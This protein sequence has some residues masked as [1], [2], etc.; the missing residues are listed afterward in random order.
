MA[1]LLLLCAP[2]AVRCRRFA[3]QQAAVGVSAQFGCVLVLLSCHP[4]AAPRSA[5]TIASYISELGVS[6]CAGVGGG[7]HLQA[8]HDARECQRAQVADVSTYLDVSGAG[9]GRGAVRDALL[10]DDTRTLD[11]RRALPP[12]PLSERPSGALGGVLGG[13][14]A[15][16]LLYTRAPPFFKGD[17]R[18]GSLPPVVAG[19]SDALR[20]QRGGV[21]VASTPF[22][23]TC[24]SKYSASSCARSRRSSSRVGS[25]PTLRMRPSARVR[26]SCSPSRH[27]CQ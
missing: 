12:P 13:G 22:T 11:A 3:L 23:P 21:Q 1:G 24:F 17:T 20:E 7:G 6:V 2:L 27:S 18:A 8:R 4:C 25:P 19:V 5:T 16:A 14:N 15:S 26:C 10:S 9:A